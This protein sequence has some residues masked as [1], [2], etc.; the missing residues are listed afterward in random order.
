MALNIT[1]KSSVLYIN[2]RKKG[3]TPGMTDLGDPVYADVEVQ[4][5]SSLTDLNKEYYVSLERFRLPLHSIPFQK[6]LNGHIKL[7][8]EHAT[9]AANEVIPVDTHNNPA[10]GRINKSLSLG[11][12]LNELNALTWNVAARIPTGSAVPTHGF[13]L[14]TDGRITLAN[15]TWGGVYDQAVPGN[16]TG[17]RMELSAYLAGLLGFPRTLRPGAANAADTG[18]C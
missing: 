8:P 15:S 14:Q 10:V 2:M 11:S 16:N 6:D 13:Y 17:Y 5:N 4:Y 3:G 1:P 9:Y 7:I 18:P 12:F